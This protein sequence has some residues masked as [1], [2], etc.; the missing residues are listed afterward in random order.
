MPEISL[1]SGNEFRN[2]LKQQGYACFKGSDLTIPN[3]IK[4]NLDLL[5]DSYKALPLDQYC[6]NGSRYRRHSR[7]VLLPWLGLIEARPNSNYHQD[8]EGIASQPALGLR[9][10]EKHHDTTTIRS[11]RRGA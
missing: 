8:R 11:W 9:K 10:P 5:R 3:H 2:D 7:Y 4:M 1:S 6:K